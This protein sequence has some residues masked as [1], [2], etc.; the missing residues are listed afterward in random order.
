MLRELVRRAAKPF[1]VAWRR[2][3][4]Y[5]LFLKGKLPD[6]ILFHPADALPKRLEE[7]DLLL[8]G[9]FRFAGETV[10]VKDVSVFDGAAHGDAWVRGLHEFEWLPPLSA[11]G[12]EAA[13]TLATN[14]ISQWIKRNSRYGEPSWAADV[15]AARLLNLFAHGRFV[16]ANSDVMWRSRLFV[17]LREQSR[18]LARTCKEAPEGLPRLE[19]AVAHVLSGACLNDSGKRLEAGLVNL[20]FQIGQ[21]ILP[22]GGHVSRSPEAL[23]R[24]YRLIVM[25]IDTLAATENQVPAGVRSAHDRMAPMLRFFRH[26]DGGLA[27]FNGGSECDARMVEALLARDE[28]RGQP[29]L[30]APHSGYQRLAS[31]KT[32]VLMDTGTPPAGAYSVGAHAGCLAFELSAAAQRIVV[33]CGA[34]N[35]GAVSWAD[36]LRTTAAH[37]TLTPADTSMATVLQTGL[38]RDLLGAR[39]LGGPTKVETSRDEIPEGWRIDGSHDGYLKEFGVRHQRSLSLSPRGN[40]LSGMDRL[41]PAQDRG[42]RKPVPFAVRFHIH[43]DVR[44]SP[45]QGGGFILKLPNGEGWRFRCSS[46]V[47]IEESVYLGTGTVRRTEQFV[48]TGSVKDTPAEI[49][50][51][52]EQMVSA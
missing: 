24:A 51:A 31:G 13:R 26:G 20:E 42:R 36:A 35:A 33:N 40:V 41:V 21:Q 48:V 32:F 5:R 11:A 16:L 49:G 46:D 3:W 43:P 10:E 29:F 23:L 15:T 6:R 45:N 38:A 12:G 28:V 39:L 30:H 52:F 4:P 19:A 22:D 18:L 14:L 27:L 17:S 2:S 44:V 50:W 9:K 34:E 25:V 8:K 7:A 47:T 37:S 1:R